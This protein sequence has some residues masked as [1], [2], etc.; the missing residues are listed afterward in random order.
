MDEETH[1]RS[2]EDS[3]STYCDLDAGE[4]DMAYPDEPPTCS[5]CL[6]GLRRDIQKAIEEY[7]E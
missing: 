1:A 7:P 5:V 3:Y 2:A 4:V 6:D